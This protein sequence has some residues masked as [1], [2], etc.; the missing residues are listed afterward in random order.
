MNYCDPQNTTQQISG[1]L[2]LLNFI[3]VL[4]HHSNTDA[5]IVFIEIIK[6]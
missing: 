1:A 4:F 3:F 2:G 5:H 6:Q